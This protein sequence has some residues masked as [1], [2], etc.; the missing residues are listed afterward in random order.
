MIIQ[1]FLNR[2]QIYYSQLKEEHNCLQRPDTNRNQS[3]TVM[4]FHLKLLRENK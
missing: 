2:G 4:T 3:E 1:S